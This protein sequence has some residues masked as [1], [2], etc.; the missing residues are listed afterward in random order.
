MIGITIDDFANVLIDE[1]ISNAEKRDCL[2]YHEILMRK[3]RETEAAGDVKQKEIYQ[4]LG[5]VASL[6]LNLEDKDEPYGPLIILKQSRSAIIEDIAPYVDI[7]IELI[8]RVNDDE[9]KAR[10]ADLVWIIKGDFKVA[11]IAVEAYL[12]HF[13]TL[14][15]PD[16]W[17]P[18]VERLERGLQIAAKLGKKGELYQKAI[19]MITDTL[20]QLNGSD[21]LF[22]SA[23]L[24]NLL[25]EQREGDPLIYGKISNKMAERAE[26]DLDWHRARC[27]WEISIQWY[28]FAKDQQEVRDRNIRLAE[29]FVSEAKQE[30]E[31]AKP[32][33]MRICQHLQQAIEAYRRIGNVA[34]KTE[35][36]HR[37]LIECQ[38]KSIEELKETRIPGPG[39]SETIQHACE[40]VSGKPL[41]DALIVLTHLTSAPQVKTLRTQVEN[42]VKHSILRHLITTV[43][44]NDAG[45]TIAKKPSMI[46]DD[47]AQR[48]AAFK[49]EMYE[50]AK[51]HQ[52]LTVVGMIE[53]ARKQI[54][55]EHKIRK[56]DL[57]SLVQYNPFIPEGREYFY[58]EGIYY[59]LIG[60]FPMSLHLLIP[61][62]E[63]SIR[64]ILAD[65]GEIVSTLENNG[66]QDERNLNSL[67]YYPEL[68]KILGEDIV[69][70]LQGLLIERFGSNLRNRSAHGL[71]DYLDFYNSEV[72][73]LWW[74]I[75]KLCIDYKLM[76]LRQLENQ[77]D[78]VND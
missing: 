60:D 39:L 5:N 23:K 36:L 10:I 34:T 58:V 33:Y 26:A 68:E 16:M 25:Q 73:Y 72:I 57:Y 67:L 24:M 42:N 15:D 22:L 74:L 52:L 28:R 76:K 71:M 18:C 29:T 51:L 75:L 46:S 56:A 70:D 31:S 59:G 30:Q 19:Q 48:E 9:F 4:L 1:I 12:K 66:V 7:L 64:S 14:M 21:P 32:S 63:N 8:P 27:Y 37:Q 61:Q 49:A 6:R 35:D 78:L 53:P 50:A 54:I 47:L 62:L 38:Q 3:M 13:I 2:D 65:N 40:M 20:D 69:F 45:K 17:P 55:S 77:A 43:A 11:Q 41:C 44:I